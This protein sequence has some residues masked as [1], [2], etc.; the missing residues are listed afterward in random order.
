PDW[1]EH[2]SAVVEKDDLR[3]DKFLQ[4]RVRIEVMRIPARQPR[5]P[6]ALL[7]LTAYCNGS[8]MGWMES[9]SEDLSELPGGQTRLG[10]VPFDVRGVLQL[11]SHQY[12]SLQYPG[13]IS[14]IAVGLRCQSLVFLQGTSHGEVNGT[15]IGRYVIHFEGGQTNVF[16]IVYGQQVLDLHTDPARM[17]IQPAWTG[18]AK[19]S[20]RKPAHL[21]LARWSNPHPELRVDHL[22]FVSSLALSSPF[23]VAVSVVERELPGN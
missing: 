3:I 2:F 15:E 14:N 19:G 23:L 18:A 10:G 22:D 7:D 9:N 8:L 4:E 20:S 12:D 17:G 6:P 16:P 5:T 21:Y 11:K 1:E 13:A